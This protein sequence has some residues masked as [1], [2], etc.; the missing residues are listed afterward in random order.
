[1]A[2]GIAFGFFLLIVGGTGIAI[3]T[4]HNTHPF[5]QDWKV[6]RIAVQTCLDSGQSAAIS[7]QDGNYE[8]VCK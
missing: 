5:T 4:Y 1:M 7:Q 2:F 3:E 6:A 8:V